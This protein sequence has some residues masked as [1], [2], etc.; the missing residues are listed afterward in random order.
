MR[1]KPFAFLTA[2]AIAVLIV[3]GCAKGSDQSTTSSSTSTTTTTSSA[4][5]ASPTSAALSAAA[6]GAPQGDAAHGKA[7]YSANCAGCHGANGVGGGIGPTLKNEKS[8]KD[9]V[10][11]IAWIK[12]PAPPMPKLYPA[13]LNEQDVNDVAAFVQTL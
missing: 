12:N 5:A 1:S 8:R 3:A 6:A 7:I 2:G 9:M 4:P 11:T 10:K 13:T